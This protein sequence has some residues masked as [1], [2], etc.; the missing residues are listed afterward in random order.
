MS[1]ADR[2]L[3]DITREEFHETIVT[4]LNTYRPLRHAHRTNDKSE[5]VIPFAPGKVKHLFVMCTV[6]IP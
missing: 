3:N 1:F 5:M 2:R 6:S 4:W